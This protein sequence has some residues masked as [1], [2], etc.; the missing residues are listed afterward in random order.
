MVLP[1][2]RIWLIGL[3]V[4]FWIVPA[5]TS[6]EDGRARIRNEY[7]A[8]GR[9]FGVQQSDVIAQRANAT[10][11]AFAKATG[12]ASVLQK[13]Y[14]T[15]EELK[16]QDIAPDLHQEL[17][18]KS[19]GYLAAMAMQMYGVVFRGL[20]LMQWL[21]VVGIFLFATIVDGFVQRRV[22]QATM[23]GNPPLLFALSLH[24]TVAVAF[25]PLAYLFLPFNVTPWF[26]PIWTLILAFPLCSAIA[27]AARMR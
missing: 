2:V 4:A 3:F 21:W 24:V 10:Y 18:K 27:N 13:G 14:T 7:D 9:I 17:A 25:A 11:D 1:H 23:R 15:D 22:R 26:T 20:L 19:N 16:R 8:V 6:D 12:F 5:L